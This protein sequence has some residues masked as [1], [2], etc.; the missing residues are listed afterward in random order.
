MSIGQG[1]IFIRRVI[2]RLKYI[3]IG[4][5]DWDFESCIDC[6]HCFHINWTVRDELWNKVMNVDD[7]GGGSLCVDCFVDRALN[8]KIFLKN[9][10]FILNIFV[11]NQD[12][13][14]YEY[15]FKRLRDVV[16]QYIANR[17]SKAAFAALKN[18]SA[19]YK[20]RKIK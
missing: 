20:S 13:F 16:G 8:K 7:G 6:G 15:E 3:F 10:D 5:Y 17:E 9:N 12:A 19:Y 11:P 2:R 4:R 14:D 18:A 1:L